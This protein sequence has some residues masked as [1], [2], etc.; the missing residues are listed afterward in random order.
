MR[1]LTDT[2]EIPG[3]KFALVSAWLIAARVVFAE[4]NFIY[5]A[6]SGETDLT[7]TNAWSSGIIPGSNDVAVFDGAVPAT[8]SLG[9]NT[10]WAGIVRTNVTGQLTLQAPA[11]GTLTLGV[12]GCK[13]YGADMNYT[14][15][16]L[17]VDVALADDQT[18]FWNSNKTVCVSGAMTGPGSLR[19]ESAG[20]D[21]GKGNALF[22]GPVT[23]SFTATET[24]CIWSMEDAIWNPDPTMA[25]GAYFYLL[26]GTNGAGHAFS[27][28]FAGGA[29]SN[30]G[31]FTFGSQDGNVSFKS[32]LN[33]F[34]LSA[35]DS[36]RG[37]GG[38]T[39]S[40]NEGHVRVQDADVVADG[41]DVT[42]NMWFDIRS[43][44]WTQKSG[45]TALSYAAIV[46]RGSSENYG[47]Q[48]Q[49]LTLDG[50]TFTSRRLSV[51]MGNSDKAPAEFRVAGGTYASTLPNA[52]SANWWAAGLAVGQRTASGESWWNNTTKKNVAVSDSDWPAGRVEIAGGKMTT[53]ALI[54]GN[55]NGDWGVYDVKSAAR[56]AVT[57]GELALG[58]GGAFT[59]SMWAPAAT[60]DGSWYDFVLSGG[61][62]SFYR[63]GSETTADIRLSDVDGG[64]QISVPSGVDNTVISG[65]LFGPGT[66]R[67]TGAGGL[68]LA[69]ANDYTGRTEVVE[70]KLEVGGRFE[71]AIWTGDD[72]SSRGAGGTA[73]PWTN[74]S[75][76]ATWSFAHT[77][78]GIPA[79]AGTTPPT[80]SLT[81]VNGH[82]AVSFN[83]SQAAFLT[84]NAPQPISGKTAC[85][86]ALV[87][88]TEPGFTGATG[89]TFLAATQIFGTSIDG[90]S[91]RLYGISINSEGK[92]GCGMGG[93]NWTEGG[94]NVTMATETLWS[95]NAVND[96]NPHVVIWSWAFNNK[97]VLQVDN[98]V[99]NRSSPSNGPASTWKTAQ[100]RII[101]GV[102]EQQS[103]LKL[104][105]GAIADMRM[106]DSQIS[107]AK[108][109]ALVREL[110]A[111]YGVA[112]FAEEPGYA[113][114]PAAAT[115]EV[116]EATAAWTADSLPQSA[117]QTVAE[118]PEKDGKKNSNNAV[119]TFT[120]AIADTILNGMNGYAGPTANP[121]IAAD[122]LNGHKLVSFS[123]TNACMALTGTSSTPAGEAN[124]L[125]VAMVVR[126]T[127]R[128]QGGHDCS[129]SGCAPFLGQ[130]FMPGDNVYQWGFG[131]TASSRAVVGAVNG[132]Y[133]PAVR[134]R[135]RFL[136]DGEAHVLVMSYPKVDSSS[137]LVFALDGVTNAVACTV[138]N[139]MQRTRIL[140]GGSEIDSKAKYVPVDVAEFRFWNGTAF[141]GDQI[142]AV[143]R[144]LGAKYSVYLDG[145]A[146]YATGAQQRSAEV[147]VHAGASY[148]GVSNHDFTLYPGQTLWGDGATTGLMTL[149]PDA[150]VLATPTNSFT[151]T[152]GA[153]FLAGSVLAAD[154]AGG[155]G[156]PVPVAVT[157]DVVLP[158]GEVKVRLSGLGTAAPQGTL[159]TWTG[160]LVKKGATTFAVEGAGAATVKVQLDE[161]NKRIRVISNTGLLVLL[162]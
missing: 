160:D 134:S 31:I 61:V 143:S 113:A 66:L 85:T 33:A 50:G 138:S 44:S 19:L 135:R 11:D 38:S 72:L 34:T 109:L 140:L 146:R 94:T 152:K 37:P 92:L 77:T 27:D 7:S 46:G 20:C 132:G 80:V 9:T 150:A 12:Q 156:A 103:T 144:E 35:G 15:T 110:G 95:T 154:F 17:A 98:D 41:A 104:F 67:K 162:L 83:G 90:R 68:R 116:P 89:D 99:Y 128:G 56:V 112:G 97:H 96:G 139:V 40:R 4:T 141:T 120:T 43:G 119:W 101:L 133:K 63:S 14:R 60:F 64:A 126:F 62:L 111:Q 87:V 53:P 142:E 42:D 118:W 48:R 124:G 76:S 25:A 155:G 39:S 106:V 93:A 26:P 114:A 129:L 149:A 148:G 29:F 131:L 24:A 137:P 32:L 73:I 145:Y 159:L 51:G 82:S 28:L 55:H 84:G 158:A 153:I 54:F 13:M 115:D 102:G 157:G 30:T 3:R 47:L 21:N 57:G 8:L 136:D 36:L 147:F 151:V 18:W 100:T 117:G 108:R 6:S 125:T 52:D 49:T 69:G 105:Q 78:T 122:A 5:L 123:G 81:N 88:R 16:Y 22:Y 91:D 107:G 65:S 2:F 79:V 127:G 70:G 23:A 121:V 10:W 45:D 59:G 130:A 58:P 86:V 75:G 161:A 1:R 74:H 71:T